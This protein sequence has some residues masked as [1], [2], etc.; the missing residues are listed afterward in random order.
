MN[1]SRA[2]AFMEAARVP[3]KVAEQ[4]FGLW[5]IRRP[6]ITQRMR[7]LL[8]EDGTFD[9]PW[10][11]L[12]I[13]YRL[14]MGTMH[15]PPGE[16]VMEDSLTEL[17]RHLPVWM[18]ARGR[19]LITGLGLGCVVRGLI[20]S[21]QVEHIDVVEIDAGILRVVGAEF[22]DNPKVSLHLGDALTFRFPVDTRWD[23]A[24]HDLWVDGDGLQDLHLRLLA[25][26]KKRVR[27][28]GAWAFPRIAKRIAR[29]TIP[30]FIG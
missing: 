21:P 6:Q 13:L 18:A 3:A 12:T 1:C 24:W 17:S 8:Q 20:A 27:Q 29:E 22:V 30:G 4:E 9:V 10:P 5:T 19:V 7:E 15:R 26:Y 25:K 16:I 14:S 23:C 11:S 2:M 28:Q